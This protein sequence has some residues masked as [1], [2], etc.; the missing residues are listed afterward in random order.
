[1]SIHNQIDL[2]TSQQKD[3]TVEYGMTLNAEL[4]FELS[5]YTGYTGATLIVVDWQNT[6]LMTF[7]TN[8]QSI[9]LHDEYFELN[10]TSEEMTTVRIGQYKYLM[11]LYNDDEKYGLM[12]G[13]FKII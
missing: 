4:S 11:Y 9:V 1:M 6:V 12:R 7:D 10:K 13:K 2:A 5:G 3:L 8:D